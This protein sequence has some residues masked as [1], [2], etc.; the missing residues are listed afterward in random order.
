LSGVVLDEGEDIEAGQFRTS[1]QE[2]KFNG[3]GG[4]IYGAS[5]RLHQ[6]H[7]GCRRASGSQQI[8]A[9]Q[10][11][12]AGLDGIF[13]NLER[14]CSVFE[15]IGDLRGLAW[16]FAGFADGNE[17]GPQPIRQSGGEYKTTG[18]DTH[19]YVDLAIRVMFAEFIHQLLKTA[20]V[21]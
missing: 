15:L 17:S 5:K 20:L 13:V 12:L 2:G 8:I 7:G 6:L 16:Q 18:P 14:V 4:A 1:F 21:L 11:A 3:K 19:H 10:D 9:D